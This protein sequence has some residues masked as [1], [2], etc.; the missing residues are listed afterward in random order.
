[1]RVDAH[2]EVPFQAV[3]PAWLRGLERFMRD[4][5]G[6][7]PFMREIKEAVERECGKGSFMV[8]LKELGKR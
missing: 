4:I 3:F 1:M 8:C 6:S 7:G 2:V 5:P